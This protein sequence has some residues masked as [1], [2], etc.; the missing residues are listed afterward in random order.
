MWYKKYI[1]MGL[2]EENYQSMI[3]NMNNNSIFDLNC[4]NTPIE[5]EGGDKQIYNN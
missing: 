2:T 5:K 3:K 4:S 1:K